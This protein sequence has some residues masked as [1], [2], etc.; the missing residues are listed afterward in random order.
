[1]LEAILYGL[2][3]A[4]FYIYVVSIVLLTID[5]IADW[6]EEWHLENEVDYDDVGFAIKESL[7]SGDVKVVQGVFN[8]NTGTVKGARRIEAEDVDRNTRIQLGKEKL[9]IFN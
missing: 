4:A 1:M 5:F 7:E 8:K 2:S 9:T 6:F 3:I